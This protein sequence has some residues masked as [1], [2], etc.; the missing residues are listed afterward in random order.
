MEHIPNRYFEMSLSLMHRIDDKLGAYIRS[1][2]LE[3]LFIWLLT[4]PALGILGVNFALLLGLMNGFL[5]MIPYFGPLMAYFPVA[6]IILI[7]NPEPGWQLFWA[8]LAMVLI[9]IIDNIVL[10]PLIVSRSMHVHPAVVLVGVL[11]GGKLAGAVGMFIAVPLYSVIQVIIVD[12]YGHL[13]SHK[14]I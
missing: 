4:W 3:S 8:S 12:L 9:Q 13:K 7:T 2:M 1:I 10:K 14:I 5:N 11:V 6:G